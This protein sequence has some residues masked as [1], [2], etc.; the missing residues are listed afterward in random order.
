M[1]NVE[2]KQETNKENENPIDLT[3]MNLNPGV[4]D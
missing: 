1:G 3:P 4:K 2:G